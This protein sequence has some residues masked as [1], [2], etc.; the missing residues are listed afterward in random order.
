MKQAAGG[1]GSSAGFRSSSAVA[2]EG[3]RRGG[4]RVDNDEGKW[5][6]LFFIINPTPHTLVID[7]SNHLTMFQVWK[8]L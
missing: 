7:H 5:N 2:R 3:G 1:G 4:E 6:K 8:L